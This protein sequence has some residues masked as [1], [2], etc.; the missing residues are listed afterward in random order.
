MCGDGFRCRTY[1]SG[2]L[3]TG[4][5]EGG[6]ATGCLETSAVET[7][8]PTAVNVSIWFSRTAYVLTDYKPNSL[9]NLVWFHCNILVIKRASYKYGDV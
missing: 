6:A 4:Q 8:L 7:A 9:L 2:R 1:V 5:L 3:F